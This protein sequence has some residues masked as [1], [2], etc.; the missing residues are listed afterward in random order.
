VVTTSGGFDYSSAL[1]V[2][3][4]RQ[5]GERLPAGFGENPETC[6]QWGEI[7]LSK[8]AKPQPLPLLLQLMTNAKVCDL[9]C[10]FNMTRAFVDSIEKSELE[11][12]P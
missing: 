1:K 2:I 3:V 7:V 8:V 12:D 10:A 11:L 9:M 4:C 6:R 5:C